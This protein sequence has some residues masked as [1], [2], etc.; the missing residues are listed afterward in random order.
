M[1]VNNFI[2]L[3]KNLPEEERKKEIYCADE[4]EG[5]HC[6]VTGIETGHV[7]Y[8]SISKKYGEKYCLIR[9]N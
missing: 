6:S 9:W 3:L 2:D 4:I 1:T 5:N 7:K 8:E